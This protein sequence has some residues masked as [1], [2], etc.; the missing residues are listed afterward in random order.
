[1]RNPFEILD[2]IGDTI[3]NGFVKLDKFGDSIEKLLSKVEGTREVAQGGSTEGITPQPASDFC[4]AC[5]PEKHIPIAKVALEE[6]LERF[7]DQKLTPEGIARV[8][9]AI[10]HLRTYSETDLKYI[11]AQGVEKNFWEDV[12]D[13]SIEIAHQLGTGGKGFNIGQGTKE[14][15]ED[16]LKALQK[17]QALAYEGVIRFGRKGVK[18]AG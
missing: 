11:D 17:L 18:H 5:G 13:V 14:D 2:G 3:E 4:P 12:R 9:T 15:L 7:R 16:I 1:M 8:R 6:A 10:D